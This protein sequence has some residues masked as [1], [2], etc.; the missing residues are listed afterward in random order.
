[1]AEND[2]TVTTPETKLPPPKLRIGLMLSH[3]FIFK[4]QVFSK[5]GASAFVYSGMLYEIWTRIKNLVDIEDADIEEI[6][7]EISY[8]EAID[9]TN[10]GE[11]DG[12]IG[13]ILISEENIKKLYSQKLYL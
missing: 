2:K 9:R 10:K 8:K 11:F 13:D 6:P 7:L 4:E 12:I 5:G 3:P 1:M